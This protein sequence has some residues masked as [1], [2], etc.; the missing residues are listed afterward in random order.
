ASM[1]E[2][3]CVRVVDSLTHAVAVAGGAAPGGSVTA[4]P[5]EVAA[6][7]DVGEVRGQPVARQA[8]EI[9]AAGGHHLLLTGPP[10]AG[11]TMLAQC[12]PSL[13]PLLDPAGQLEVAQVWAAADRPRTDHARPPLRA[14]HHTATSAALV[15]GG[16]GVP[17]PGEISLAHKG[18]L[19]LDEMG[20]FPPALLDALR[21]PLEQGSV[22]IARKGRT[23]TFPSDIQL[24]GATN[25]CPCGY[26]EDEHKTCICTLAA[27]DRYRRRMSGPLL[28]R[29][30]IRVTVGRPAP[31]Q[32]LGPA[33]EPSAAIRARVLAA[34]DRQ[35]ARGV[36]NRHLT[37]AQLD[38]LPIQGAA[39]DLVASALRT[40]TV[41]GRGYDRTRRL[42]RTIADLAGTSEVTSEHMWS[43]LE[44][45]GS[46]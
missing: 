12:L 2:G 38:D 37:R 31:D 13:L 18:V 17:V 1:V 19:F 44:L 6:A 10:G 35:L 15:G 22:T 32:M 4:L 3:A 42:A 8:L 29:F 27:K 25:P 45:R 26:H 11:K 40:G 34:R 28:D 39:A 33:E 30:D 36:L 23:T 21:Q 16:S 5:V 7:P 41:T 43:A 9:A 24:V 20:E 14:P 46:P